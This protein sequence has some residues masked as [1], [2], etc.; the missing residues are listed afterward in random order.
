MV[1]EDRKNYLV[2]ILSCAD[3]SL[4]TGLTT[5]LERRLAEHNSGS[6]KGARYT[7]ARRPVELVWQSVKALDR[8][9]AGALEYQIKQMTRQQKLRWIA[10]RAE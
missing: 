4:Y 2:Y 1:P 5:D 8:S 9:A 7:R 3:G 6:A 10:Q